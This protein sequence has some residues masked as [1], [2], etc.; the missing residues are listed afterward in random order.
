MVTKDLKKIWAA[1]QFCWFIDHPK[2]Q[3]KF[4]FCIEYATEGWHWVWKLFCR[5]T[6]QPLVKT[7]FEQGFATCFA[8]G[9]TGSGKTHTMG[10]DFNGKVQVGSSSS[11]VCNFLMLLSKYFSSGFWGHFLNWPWKIKRSRR[12]LSEGISWRRRKLLQDCSRG[13]YALTARDVFKYLN[14]KEYK[15]DGLSVSC[16]FFELYGDKVGSSS[17]N[18]LLFCL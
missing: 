5:F 3:D 12:L 16:S 2:L 1:L 9:Q 10:G 8:Y 4:H 13:I 7:V 6:A 11:F 15:R 14:G 17:S 18:C